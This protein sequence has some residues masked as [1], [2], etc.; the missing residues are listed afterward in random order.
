MPFLR[1]NATRSRGESSVVNGL[2]LDDLE[3][4]LRVHVAAVR[5]GILLVS[6]PIGGGAE[7]H[8]RI[9]GISVEDGA[10]P[11]IENP[12]PVEHFVHVTGG[13]MD[14][15]H[16]EA[17][18]RGLS[19]QESHH[20]LRIRRGES[21][22][23]LVHEEDGRLTEKFQSDVQPFPL[24]AADALL[25]RCS[26]PERGDVGLLQLFEHLTAAPADLLVA[27]VGKTEPGVVIEIL[28]DRE[29]LEE[30]IVLGNV[31]EKPLQPGAVACHLRSVDGETPRAWCKTPREHAEQGGFSRTAPSH[32]RHEFSSGKGKTEVVH[33]RVR[34][35]GMAE[36]QMSSFEAKD[37]PGPSG[38]GKD[39]D[40]FRKVEAFPLG[41]A[42]YRSRLQE[43][44][45][46]RWKRTPVQEKVRVEGAAEVALALAEP[47]DSEGTRHATTGGKIPPPASPC[48]WRNFGEMDQKLRTGL[49]LPEGPAAEEAYRIEKRA[50]HAEGLRH[51][52]V[53]A[54]S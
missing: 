1:G 33:S 34:A 35:S 31:T 50:F 18:L 45:G 54:F 15:R 9:Q 44:D 47:E 22:G 27:A 43:S 29:V 6:G 28:K 8:E 24:P 36:L 48:P 39:R 11:R 40:D 4:L 41:R 20:V 32:D 13:L 46:M 49:L 26:H 12:Q 17:P 51:E 25:Q 21:A 7:R 42:Q 5:T 23:R 37:L 14:H 2:F 19:L 3:E 10:S 38:L 52:T 53:D 16:D 30:Q